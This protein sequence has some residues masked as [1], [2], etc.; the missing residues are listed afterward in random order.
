VASSPAFGAPRRKIIDL[1]RIGA[2]N[3]RVLALQ[4]YTAVG[5]VDTAFRLYRARFVPLIV[6][7]L[8]VSVPQSGSALLSNIWAHRLEKIEPGAD[9][10]QVLGLLGQFLGITGLTMLIASVVVVFGTAASAH[11]ASE[12]ALGRRATVVDAL[13][14]A[15]RCFFPLLG[16]SLLT[17]LASS[18]GLLM[19]CV[20]GILLW[21]AFAL[22]GPVFV[23][24]RPGVFEGIGRTWRLGKGRWLRIFATLLLTSGVV[25]VVTGG[26]QTITEQLFQTLAPTTGMAGTVVGTLLGQVVSVLGS[27]LSYVALVLLYY[28]ARVEQEAFDVQLLTRESM[29]DAAPAV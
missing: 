22:I 23:V 14:V 15:L 17:G 3:W 7:S 1:P 12:A 13:R 25:V 9:P 16:A 27:P 5:A 8:V 20:P 21:L 28:D 26:L 10:E 19:C 24:E 29:P 4:R 2:S 6:I 11:I 18:I